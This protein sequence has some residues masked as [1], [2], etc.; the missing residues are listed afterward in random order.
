MLPSSV[1]PG[2]IILTFD[3]HNSSEILHEQTIYIQLFDYIK[4]SFKLNWNIPDSDV[5]PLIQHK[6]SKQKVI[7]LISADFIYHTHRN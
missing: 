4:S 5:D 1:N 2:N 7:S 6:A 3:N